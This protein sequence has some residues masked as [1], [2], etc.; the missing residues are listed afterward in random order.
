MIATFRAN[1]AII[2]TFKTFYVIKHVV[3]DSIDFLVIKEIVLRLGPPYEIYE[4]FTHLD[5]Q[6]QKLQKNA[7]L[8]VMCEDDSKEAKETWAEIR[9]YYKDQG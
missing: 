4:K 5:Q 6:I 9:E 2:I 8:D 7:S 1:F 3:F